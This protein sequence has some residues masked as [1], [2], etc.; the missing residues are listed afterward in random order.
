MLHLKWHYPQLCKQSAIHIQLIIKSFIFCLFFLLALSGHSQNEA[1]IWY[2]GKGYGLQFDQATPKIVQKGPLEEGAAATYSNPAGQVLLYANYRGV[3]NKDNVLLENDTWQPLTSSPIYIIPKPGSPSL[4]YIFYVGPNT[5]SSFAEYSVRYVTVDLTANGGQ[6]AIIEKLTVLYKD[7]HGSFTISGQ[8]VNNTYWLVGETNTNVT[9]QKV[10]QLLAFKITPDGVSSRA[11]RSEPVPIGNS[12]NLKLSPKGDKIVFGYDGIPGYEGTGLADFNAATGEVAKSFVLESRGFGM[13]FSA[14]GN[15]L[16]L[17]DFSGKKLWQFDISSGNQVAILASKKLIYDG[18]V[19]LTSPQLAPDGRIYFTQP[20]NTRALAV[21]NYPERDG[22]ACDMVPNALILPTDVYPFL[23]TFA[24]NFLYSFPGKP[25]AGP[26]KEICPSQPVK[27]GGTPNR[28]Y[29]Y[30]W[31]PATY[32]SDPASP[33]PVFLYPNAITQK[34]DFV[35]TLYVN[36][37]L[38]ELADG[39]TISVMPTPEKEKITGSQ[40]VCPGVEK[41][42]Y[43]VIKREGYTYRWAVSGGQLISGQGTAAIQVNWGP[44]NTQAQVSLIILNESGCESEPIILPV[45]INVV[46]IPEK[47]QGP[48]LICQNLAFN[49]LYTVTYTTGSLY[50]WGI[51]GGVITSGQGSNHVTVDW[52]GLG[53]HQ[54]WIQEQS[55]TVDTVCYGVSDTLMVKVYQDNTTI[56]IENISLNPQDE[57]QVQI[58]WSSSDNDRLQEPFDLYRREYGKSN[59]HLISD[60]VSFVTPILDGGLNSDEFVYEYQ[61]ST[62][63]GCQQIITSNQHHTIQLQNKSGEEDKNITLSWNAYEGWPNGVERYEIWRRLDQE[64]DMKLVGQLPGSLLT[65]AD[66]STIDGFEHVYW[67]K[68]IAKGSSFASWSN[69]IQLTFKHPLLPPNVFTPNNDGVNDLFEIRNLE[70]YPANQLRIY[71]RW[72]QEVYKASGYKNNWSAENVTEGTYFYQL[73]LLNSGQQIK[74]W[75]EVVR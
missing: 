44:S 6:G 31:E 16:Y 70:L 17:L 27:L 71:N 39:V 60:S 69:S 57:K 23:P 43:S 14:S 26:D 28:N 51:Q 63:N 5:A 32:L 19:Q 21:I 29:T 10:D 41:V 20:E 38:C 2:L 48:E 75:I 56:T 52:S 61:I 15:K 50:T 22:T 46:L 36:D 40:S 49:Q 53:N 59:W 65:F 67:V 68:A 3:F 12:S 9:S 24:A 47:P 34:K 37:G 55:T 8:C 25:D 35:Y 45:R 66:L 73:L 30:R 18:P 11:I 13:E 62:R 4:F 42:D 74:G 1:S 54:L 72:G 64:S 33:T 58:S 7:L